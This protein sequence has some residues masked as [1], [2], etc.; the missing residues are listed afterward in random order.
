MLDSNLSSRSVIV[1]NVTL[2]TPDINLCDLHN[3]NGFETIL[4]GTSTQGG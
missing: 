4:N 1:H 3:A 2:I